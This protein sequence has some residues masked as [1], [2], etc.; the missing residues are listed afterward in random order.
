[1]PAEQ[2][3]NL[4]HVPSCSAWGSCRAASVTFYQFQAS[5]LDNLQVTEQ[6]EEHSASR[7]HA[8][9]NG[10]DVIRERSE[11]QLLA[12]QQQYYDHVHAIKQQV[13]TCKLIDILFPSENT[14]RDWHSPLSYC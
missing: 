3:E 7:Q 5:H 12:A 1:M 6:R 14:K 4:A 13:C 11:Q 9:Q 2:I 10:I 8:S